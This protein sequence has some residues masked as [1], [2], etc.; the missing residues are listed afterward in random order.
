MICSSWPGLESGGDRIELSPT[1]LQDLAVGVV[2]DLRGSERD[3]TLAIHFED[4]MP[5]VQTDVSKVQQIL[6]NL[7]TNAFKYAPEGTL[8]TLRGRPVVDGVVVSVQD[9]ELGIPAE[10]HEQVFERFFQ[11]DHS[12]TRSKGGV[13]LGLYICRKLATAIGGRLWLER[14]DEHGSVF[15]L[16]IPVAAS[17]ESGRDAADRPTAE[18]RIA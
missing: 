12:S 1:S 7:V 14:S 5:L 9:Q 15:S 2:E 6:S 3:H 10:L 4:S 16:W 13:G 18:A 11:A 17:P 8:V